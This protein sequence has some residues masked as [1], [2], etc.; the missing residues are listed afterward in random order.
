MFKLSYTFEELNEITSDLN[1]FDHILTKYFDIEKFPTYDDYFKSHTNL[2]LQNKYKH[3]YEDFYLIEY[4]INK[5]PIEVWN[6]IIKHYLY[7]YIYKV[8][9]P[10]VQLN[11]LYHLA[12]VL[13]TNDFKKQNRDLK[14]KR[15][16]ILY[17]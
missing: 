1:S 10:F 2:E 3:I 11:P 13:H 9:I 4:R 7:H 8:N 12:L 5:L 16:I 15:L 14:K 6:I 17:F